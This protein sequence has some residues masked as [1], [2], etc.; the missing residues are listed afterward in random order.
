MEFAGRHFDNTRRERKRHPHSHQPEKEAELEPR[1]SVETSR[2]RDVAQGHSSIGKQ[3]REQ[4]DQ[5][6]RTADPAE[7]NNE[8]RPHSPHVREH[9]KCGS[10]ERRKPTPQTQSEQVQSFCLLAR[11]CPH[12]VSARDSRPTPPSPPCVAARLKWRSRQ[13]RS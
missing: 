4:L 2:A 5:T 8:N 12:G 7:A 10:R 3:P 6:K 9:Q 11:V 13:S 1:H